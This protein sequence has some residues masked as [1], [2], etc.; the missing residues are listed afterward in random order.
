[1]ARASETE[2]AQ[3]GASG[4]EKAR[5]GASETEKAQLGNCTGA[6]RARFGY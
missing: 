2:K 4:T 3:L 6:R 1:M 5:M